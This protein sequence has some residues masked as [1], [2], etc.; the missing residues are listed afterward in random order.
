MSS[1][2]NLTGGAEPQTQG[3]EKF[4]RLAISEARRALSLG[5]VPIGAVVVA[6]GSVVGRGH[7]LVETLADA[8]A[9]AEMQALTAASATLGGKYLQQ[10]TLYVTVEPCIMCAG[11]IGWSQVSRV[12]W[13]AD[14]PK[15]GY[16][17]FCGRVF[18]PKAT[19][20]AGVLRE[21]CEALMR[22]FFADLR[23]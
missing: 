1:G 21:E 5:E 16:R 6:G 2:I 19:F 10:C 9:H 20:T 8:T 22:G 13:G 11:A 7:N 15:R 17:C 23:G 12:V 14:D 18:H 4:M 3:D